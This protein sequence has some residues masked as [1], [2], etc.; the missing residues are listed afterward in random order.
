MAFGRSR[1][2]SVVVIAGIL[3]M[4]TGPLFAA[5]SHD[6]CDAMRHG[7]ARLDALAS[8]CCNGSDSS[9]SSV[10]STPD[11]AHSPHAM[12]AAAAVFVMPAVTLA[13]VREGPPDLARSPDFRILFGDLRL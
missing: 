13:L 6:A 12:S 3:A 5:Q 8:C 11:V 4:T 10:P 1:T 9:A 7:C 2:F